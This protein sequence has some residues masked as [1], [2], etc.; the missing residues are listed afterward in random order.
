MPGAPD[1]VTEKR[2]PRFIRTN[3]LPKAVVTASMHKVTAG[4]QILIGCDLSAVICSSTMVPCTT[5][6]RRNSAQK[7][8]PARFIRNIRKIG[9]FLIYSD[10]P[11]FDRF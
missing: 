4:E 3:A 2:E 9:D 7:S 10:R 8:N 11:V 5:G 1:C 6:K